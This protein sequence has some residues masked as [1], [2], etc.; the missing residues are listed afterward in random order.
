MMLGEEEEEEDN[1]K[2]SSSSSS[3][4]Y[5]NDNGSDLLQSPS[6]SPPASVFSEIAAITTPTTTSTAT[7][8][9]NTNNTSCFPCLEQPTRVVLHCNG[10]YLWG[11]RNGKVIARKRRNDKDEWQLLY[12]V[13][14]NNSSMVTIQNHKFNSVLSVVTTT[15]TSK[16]TTTSTT[17]T[18]TLVVTEQ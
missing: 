11:T 4:D 5:D 15:T 10:Y 18:G 9:T 1:H 8:T 12:D 6:V 16:T 7:T 13:N 3:K 14:D 2:I 17:T